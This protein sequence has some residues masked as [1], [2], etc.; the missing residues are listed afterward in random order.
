M[1]TSAS[2]TQSTTVERCRC[3]AWRSTDTTLARMLSATYLMLLSLLD[4]NLNGQ[5]SGFSL[6]PATAPSSCREVLRSLPVWRR[7]YSLCFS[8]KCELQSCSAYSSNKGHFV[9]DSD[10]STLPPGVVAVQAMC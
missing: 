1:E 3:T 5:T 7:D 10:S 8:C 2:F 4:R 9:R 6:T